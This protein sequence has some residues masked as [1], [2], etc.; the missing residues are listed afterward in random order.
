MIDGARIG[1]RGRPLIEE[2][3]LV[4]EPGDFLAIVGPN[5][6]GKTTLLRTILGIIPP[7]AGSV[8]CS[9]PIGY[10]P[11]RQ[12]LDPI[13]PFTA[14][15]VVAMGLLRPR[16]DDDPEPNPRQLAD[17]IAEAL[18]ACGV[19]ALADRPFRDLSGGQR[20]RVLL[21]R[22]MVSDPDVLVLDEPTN[23][24]DLAGEHE[25]MELVSSLNEAGRSVIIVSHMLH[26]VARHAR[27]IALI[28][29]RRIEHGEVGLML[30]PARLERL[31]G[32]PV[33]VHELDRGLMVAPCRRRG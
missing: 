2:L 31:Y 20:Q 22:A 14:R 17:R 12:E 28:H 9:G 1:H 11:Q 4:L 18:A 13:F 16:A 30:E 23:D 24:L 7:L 10:A 19:A 33:A 15:E 32:I 21:A 29:E 27:R 5:G 26:V 25:V 8:H 3:S 6:S